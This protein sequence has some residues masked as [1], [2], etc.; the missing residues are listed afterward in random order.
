MLFV[1]N[2]VDR[3]WQ[4]LL[5]QLLVAPE[6]S[7][8][9]LPCRELLGVT[10]RLTDARANV[11]T[12][13]ARRLSYRFAVA[14]W[15]WITFGHDDVATIAP[16]NRHIAQFSDDGVVFAGAYGPPVTQQL[17]RVL[18]LLRADPD[19]RQ[20]VIVIYRPP[21]GPTRDVPCT[22]AL[23]FLLRRGELHTHATMRSSDA[24]LGLPYDV[25]NF[26]QLGGCI[27]GELGA[28]VGEFTIHL[29][30]S[31]LY[32][33]NYEQATVAVNTVTPSISSP[34]LPGLPPREL[35]EVLRTRSLDPL[36]TDWRWDGYTRALTAPT[37]GA[38]LE[39]LRGFTP[40]T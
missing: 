24:W 37:N 38:A 14:E 2:D 27:A 34:Q 39:V 28:V 21:V 40:W 20:A 22:L 10:L 16:Y 1:G 7:P 4:D 19:T 15:L 18:Q 25:Y 8:R 17:P 6:V 35:D 29:G 13:P 26:T 11:L 9:K 36:I 3:L 32:A 12:C 33:S 5:A 30:S 23:Q 31:H